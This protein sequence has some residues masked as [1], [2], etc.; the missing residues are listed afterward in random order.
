MTEIASISAVAHS[1]EKMTTG[2]TE[3]S[4]MKLSD[5]DGWL[6]SDQLALRNWF[7]GKGSLVLLV[8]LVSK[9]SWE[10]HSVVKI[11]DPLGVSEVSNRTI[12]LADGDRIEEAEVLSDQILDLSFWDRLDMGSN[13]EQKNS[14]TDSLLRD[15]R[16]SRDHRRVTRDVKEELPDVIIGVIESTRLS[17]VKHDSEIEDDV[18]GALLHNVDESTKRK[19]LCDQITCGSDLRRS[20]WS[21][22][23]NG[24][25]GLN[26]HHSLRRARRAWRGRICLGST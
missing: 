17:R 20:C 1:A 8:I 16:N 26:W 13:P 18:V 11:P 24:H 23:S 10:D 2:D 6:S 7:F 22:S 19:I 21:H 12:P 4:T 15:S 25:N 5:V 9:A 14:S 3:L